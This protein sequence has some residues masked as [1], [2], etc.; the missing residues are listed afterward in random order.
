MNKITVGFVVQEYDENGKCISS[1]F[2]AGDQ[3]TWEND[4]GET[5][6]EPDNAECF[7]LSMV[8]P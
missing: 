4:M 2:I 8:Q 6:D 1:E 7:P 5:I 3:T